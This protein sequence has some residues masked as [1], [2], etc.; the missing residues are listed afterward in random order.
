M[1]KNIKW[2]LLVSLTF[3]ACNNDDE[4][5]VVSNSS[6]GLPLT[7]GSANFSKYVALGDSFAAG[8][9]DGALFKKGQEG[10]YPSVVAQQFALVGGGTFT[11]PFMADNIGGFL[12]MGN[13]ADSRRLYFNGVGP[14]P[15]SGPPTTEITTRLTGSFNNMGLPGAKSFHLVT[16]GYGTLNPYF[17]RFAS[18]SSATVLADAANQDA[19]FFSLW[20]GGNDVLTYATSG[21]IGVNRTGNTNPA[22]YGTNDITDPN[23]FAG[24]FTSLVTNLTAKGAKG[25]VA[26]L[27]YINTL[28]YFTTVPTSPLSPAA[29][30]GAVG[31]AQINGL[32]TLLRTALGSADAGRIGLLSAAAANP[33][34]IKDESLVDKAPQMIPVL[35][36]YFTQ[37]GD[38][39]AATNAAIFASIFGQARQATAGDYVLLTTSSV[40]GS[41]VPGAPSTINKFGITYPLQDG[42]VLTADETMQVKTATDAYNGTIKAVADSK[43]LA[44]VDTKAIMDKLINGGIASNGFTV[45]NVFVT[46]G[47]FS[48]D[49]VHPSPRG[50]ALIANKFIEAINM[51]YGSNLKG[52][53]L[54]N[55]RILFPSSL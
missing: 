26:N 40:I 10:A 38:P 51:T 31:V 22:T 12:F 19:T 43:G 35:T 37:Q 24:A 11:T 49:G 46:G 47:G 16:P 25:V 54:G 18:S 52:V 17:G 33:L 14:V 23:V 20:I 28:P 48:L 27:P 8:Y 45:T 13:V 44:F 6:D 32:Y 55:Y 39:N 53:D 2:L 5:V 3:V 30:G 34:L 41:T 4:V 1:I 50:Y 36:G 9:S 21:G 15:V 29:L 42:H 7:S